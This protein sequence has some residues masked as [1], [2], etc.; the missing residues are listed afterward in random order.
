MA[1]LEDKVA[2]V[3]AAGGTNHVIPREWLAGEKYA[4]TS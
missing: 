4:Q 2:L 3:T 1:M